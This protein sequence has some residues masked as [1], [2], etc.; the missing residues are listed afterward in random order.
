MFLEL[1]TRDGKWVCINVDQIIMIQGVC[2]D[3]GKVYAEIHLRD[4]V[5][6]NTLKPY[7]TIISKVLRF[8]N[9]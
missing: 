5:V 1:E 8:N 7:R 2:T 4:G 6:I 9:Y 3:G